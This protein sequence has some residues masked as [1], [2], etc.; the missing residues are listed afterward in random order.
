MA[1]SDFA[2]PATPEGVPESPSRDAP[3]APPGR[4]DAGVNADE[5]SDSAGEAAAPLVSA[6]ICTRNRAD[7]V[8]RAVRSALAQTEP[9]I[10]VIV[11]DDGSTD[12]TEAVLAA[13]D[14]DR[15]RV[16]VGAERCGANVRRNQGI[17]AACA[18]VVALLDSDDWWAPDRIARALAVLRDQD[19][20]RTVVLARAHFVRGGQ[21]FADPLPPKPADRPV[22]DHVYR[23]GGAL[24]TSGMMVPTA[25]ARAVPFDE[26]LA[27]N[28]DTDFLMRLEAASARIVQTEDRLYYLDVSPRADR[29]TLN[30]AV[31]D[32]SRAWS[33]RAG[34]RW[35]RLT[36]RGYRMH[37]LTRR[38]LAA[39]RRGRALVTWLGCVDPRLDPRGQLRIL[40]QILFVAEDPAPLR[41]LRAL[42][43][44]L[45]GG[46]RDAE[47]G[48]DRPASGMAA[49][50]PGRA[51]EGGRSS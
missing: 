40:L 7:L 22:A 25:L 11:V 44:K 16:I 38:Y 10:E 43:D 15:L 30:P 34:A 33:A 28:Q 26:T 47:P 23:H 36:R 41:R 14:D 6:V 37:D 5:R 18:P 31:I 32:A 19:A 13:I 17:A 27:V 9:R 51:R 12:A 1:P 48:T 46:D 24:Q 39:G 21:V 35:P 29:T 50:P 8:V 2:R 45:R 4:P 3:G 42:R 49:M 20:E